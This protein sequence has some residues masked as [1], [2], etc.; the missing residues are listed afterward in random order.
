M[1]IATFWFLYTDMC[2]VLDIGDNRGKSP[3]MP[4]LMSKI[5]EFRK[6]CPGKRSPVSFV[7]FKSNLILRQFQSSHG[8]HLWYSWQHKRRFQSTFQL[9]SAPLIFLWKKFKLSNKSNA[10]LICKNYF[11]FS[12]LIYQLKLISTAKSWR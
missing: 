12:T 4:I 1:S 5:V 6:K 2:T 11:Y 9:N 3:W 8:Q 10:A 7:V